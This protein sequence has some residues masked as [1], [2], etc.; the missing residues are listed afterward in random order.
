MSDNRE[1]PH[2]EE[3]ERAVLGSVIV[4]ASDVL[5]LV[6]DASADHFFSPAN[7]VVW[8]AIERIS[9]KG[10]GVDHVAVQDAL[11]ADAS[12]LPG[13]IGY[14]VDLAA[15]A[16][17]P[18]QVERHAGRIATMA[19]LRRL[20]GLCVEVQSRAY[21]ASDA[22]EIIGEARDGIARLD[23][24]GSVEAKRLAE[25]VD[26]ATKEIE[27]RV[28]KK[29]TVRARF[30]IAGVDKIV[31]MRR[32]RLVVIAGLPGM[33]KTAV[34]SGILAHNAINGV[35]GL[36]FS[37]EM[38]RQEMV[39]RLISLRSHVPATN[40]ERGELTVEQWKEDVK[41]AAKQIWEWPLWID[42]RVLSANQ[43]IGASNRWW[44]KNIVGQGN[45]F[46]LIAIDYLNL[47]RSDEHSEN[48]NR[49]VAKLGQ[50]FKG[51]AKSLRTTV[52]LLAQLNRKAA[53]QGGEPKMSHL[54]DSGELEATADV[55]ICPWRESYE[56]HTAHKL[57]DFE[58]EKAKWIVLKN[59]GGSTGYVDVLWHRE[60]M[61]YADPEVTD[62]RTRR[63][64]E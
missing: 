14:V 63:D 7:Q 22:D 45:D 26:E 44:A 56:K 1:P 15:A 37:L 4:A 8:S 34:E 54:R 38:D 48:R 17:H 9:A 20:I 61:E 40:L 57:R 51:L 39:E 10:D 46:G 16:V 33:G 36:A 27:L 21:S 42:D 60:R 58:P 19:R 49:E 24:S 62:L 35:P 53:D 52:I 55:I 18:A 5:P 23:S 31:R 6:A 3:S 28:E 13:G 2:S 59:K 32:G 12:R 30:G 64:W 25:L 41:K 29:D 47:V 43:I 50:K 11:K